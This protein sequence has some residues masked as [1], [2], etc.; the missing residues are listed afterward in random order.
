MQKLTEGL[1]VALFDRPSRRFTDPKGESKNTRAVVSCRGQNA[2]VKEF[3]RSFEEALSERRV[4][5][6]T[7][8]GKL[9]QFRALLG[10]E[11]RRHFHYYAHEEVAVLTPV[12]MN[13]S[14]AAELKHLSAL[15]ASGNFQVGFTFQCR[16][17][18]FAT[19][20]SKRKWNGHFTVEIVF[21][22]LENFVLLNVDDDVKIALRPAANASFAITR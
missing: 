7:H 13:Y 6:A 8:I 5:F 22:A 16:H 18:H 9:L 14:L 11:T 15:C 17:G 12:H 3:F 21:V 4:F 1:V 2:S 10:V 19:E 20:R